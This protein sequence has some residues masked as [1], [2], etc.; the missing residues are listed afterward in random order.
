DIGF[1]VK[2]GHDDFTSIAERLADSNAD[3][4]HKRRGIHAKRDFIGMPRVHQ[5]SDTAA[6]LGDGLV[7]FLRVLVSPASLH[8]AMEKM[9]GNR[10]EYGPGSLGAGGVIEKNKIILE[11]REG[12]AHLIDGKL[13]CVPAQRQSTY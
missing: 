4:P 9:V 7:H 3:Q 1:V 13:Y 8:I 2:I 5:Q 11:R 12:A 10:A 6:G